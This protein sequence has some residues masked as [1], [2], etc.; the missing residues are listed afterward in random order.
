MKINQGSFFVATAT[1]NS[2]TIEEFEIVRNSGYIILTKCGQY[3][4]TEMFT[5][6]F[7][8]EDGKVLKKAFLKIEDADIALLDLMD[9]LATDKLSELKKI[10]LELE[11]LIKIRNT[12]P[13]IRRKDD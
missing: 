4:F 11:K 6:V 7:E 8:F 9:K 12:S 2:K 1:Y 10:K 3:F 5:K 13:I